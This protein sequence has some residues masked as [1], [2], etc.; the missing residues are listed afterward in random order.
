[1]TNKTMNTIKSVGASMAIGAALGAA[2]TYMMNNKKSVAKKGRKALKAIGG[3]MD[4]IQN[5][6]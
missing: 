3:M 4:D 2:G 5:I 6:F 1:M